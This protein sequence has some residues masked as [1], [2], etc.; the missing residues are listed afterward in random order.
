MR[1]K[2]TIYFRDS[3]RQPIIKEGDDIYMYELGSHTCFKSSLY[4]EP[5]QEM[6]LSVITME[7][8]YVDWEKVAN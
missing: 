1:D 2:I 8:L 3:T 5:N 4:K 6:M 7:L